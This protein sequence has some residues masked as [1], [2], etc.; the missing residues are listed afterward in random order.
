MSSSI[1]FLSL[2]LTVSTIIIVKLFLIQSL[3]P[4][5][6]LRTRLDQIHLPP[7][8]PE[9]TPPHRFRV[10]IFDSF[11]IRRSILASSCS[12]PLHPRL[13]DSPSPPPLPLASFVSP[14]RLRRAQ[15]GM[16]AGVDKSFIRLPRPRLDG[17]SSS[18]IDGGSR[19][20]SES[21]HRR[22]REWAEESEEENKERMRVQSEAVELHSDFWGRTGGCCWMGWKQKC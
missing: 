4:L 17:S 6:V 11:Q 13:S 18:S 12:L 20:R 7:G 1:I 16:R 3:S 10:I 5:L 9:L 8:H 21:R 19:G 15:R 2:K 22:R 14:P